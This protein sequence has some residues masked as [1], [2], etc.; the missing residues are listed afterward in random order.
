MQRVISTKVD[1]AKYAEFLQHCAK[2][3]KYPSNVLRDALDLLLNFGE[4]EREHKRRVAELNSRLE[5][6][7]REHERRVAEL[8][9]KVTILV[10]ELRKKPR[11]ILEKVEVEK[12]EECPECHRDIM[13][14]N[15]KEFKCPHCSTEL[16]KKDGGIRKRPTL[17]S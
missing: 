4:V 14:G 16:I 11:T 10:T 15:L 7:K 3:N 1:Q 5:E 2:V 8:E 13:L 6:I 9:G 17:F 12:S